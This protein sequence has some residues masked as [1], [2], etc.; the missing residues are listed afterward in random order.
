MSALDQL[1]WQETLDIIC[2]SSARQILEGISFAEFCLRMEGMVPRLLTVGGMPKKQQ[3]P[4]MLCGIATLMAL[5]IWNATP[6]PENRFRPRKQA[7]PERNAPC[8][9]RFG[10]K[11]QTVLCCGQHAG[12]GH[13]RRIDADPGAGSDASEETG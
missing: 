13:F 10:K 9:V 4:E 11:V 1:D 5:E 2:R 3:S 8:S 12:T 7:R 6:I